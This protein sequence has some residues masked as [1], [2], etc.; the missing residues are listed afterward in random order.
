M[1]ITN[2]FR[3]RVLERTGYSDCESLLY[4]VNL[5]KESIVHL[6][7]H[8]PNLRWFPW[9][10]SR[11]I[12]NPFSALLVLECLNLCLV[13]DGVNLVTVYNLNN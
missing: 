13:T 10:K 11:L 7:K 5:H 3:K 9:L 1:N 2:H 12:K 8:S 6:T 4:D